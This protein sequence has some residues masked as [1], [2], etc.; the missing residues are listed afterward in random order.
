MFLAIIA[1]LV[2]LRTR[3]TGSAIRYNILAGLFG[4]FLLASLGTFIREWKL[5]S[6]QDPAVQNIQL[7]RLTG[8]GTE[9]AQKSNGMATPV[10]DSDLIDTVVIYF[11]THAS[12]VVLAWLIVFSARCVKMMANMHY[13][14]RIKTQKINTPP[15]FWKLRIRELAASLGID[16]PVTLLESKL[17]KVPVMVGWVKPVI[18]FP[19]ALLMQLP[20]GQVEAVLLHELAHIRR[21]DYCVN[22]LQHFA[23]TIFF[24]NPGLLWLSSL[25]RDERENCCDDIAIGQTRSKKQF[26]HALVAFQEYHLSGPRYATAFPGNKDQLLQRVYLILNN[27]NITLDMREKL[28]LVVCLAI[29]GFFT[30]AYSQSHKKPAA[31]VNPISKITPVTDTVPAVVVTSDSLTGPGYT[32]YEKKGFQIVT[33]DDSI[34][35]VYLRGKKMSPQQIE[36]MRPLIDEVLAA[37]KKDAEELSVRELQLAMS[38]QNLQLQQEK[39]MAELDRLSQNQ[40]EL[41]EQHE[42]MMADNAL[43][44]QELSANGRK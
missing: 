19:F 32:I 15:D 13:I 5:S 21:R 8:S 25:I 35:S 1:G 41:N 11:N 33:K 28:F 29:V 10:T 40:A 38:N 44:L 30:I 14:R 42:K 18:L 7:D 6:L 20:A 22:L 23:E 12:L 34:T 9:S 39:K 27:V 43:R 2:I 17:V 3:T 37:S 24:F 31:P 16:R 4:L 36:D 26:V